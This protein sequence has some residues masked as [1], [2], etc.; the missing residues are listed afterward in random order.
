M[1]EI[2]KHEK[3]R[4]DP[5]PLDVEHPRDNAKIFGGERIIRQLHI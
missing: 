2:S 3:I 4:S 5:V 1:G